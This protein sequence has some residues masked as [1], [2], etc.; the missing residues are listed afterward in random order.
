MFAKSWTHTAPI[1]KTQLHTN[2]GT[3]SDIP[4]VLGRPKLVLLYAN[5]RVNSNYEPPPGLK[6]AEASIIL[7]Y[8]AV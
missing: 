6:Y 5:R 7:F 1:H 3:F 2:K 8:V 4:K